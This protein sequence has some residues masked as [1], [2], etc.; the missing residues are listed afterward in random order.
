MHK[1]MWDQMVTDNPALREALGRGVEYPPEKQQDGH[2]RRQHHEWDAVADGVYQLHRGKVGLLCL[3]VRQE[4][5]APRGVMI[6]LIPH[7]ET[8]LQTS[9]AL[10]GQRRQMWQ[11][12]RKGL[13]HVF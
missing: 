7:N 10:K 11:K 12:Y 8:K 13:S 4:R 1:K 3:K 5:S 9:S 6:N 2:S